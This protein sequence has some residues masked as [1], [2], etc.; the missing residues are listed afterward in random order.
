MSGAML[1][2]QSCPLKARTSLLHQDHSLWGST[3]ELLLATA[4]T[5]E[6]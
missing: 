2:S 6:R 1:V 4:F 5:G 3:L